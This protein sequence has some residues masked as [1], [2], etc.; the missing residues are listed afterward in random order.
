MK[1]GCYATNPEVFKGRSNQFALVPLK[2]S[3]YNVEIVNSIAS[4]TLTQTY[5]NPTET[6]LELE[7][8]FPINP[9][10]CL[11]K[12]TATFGKTKIEGIVKDSE[13]AKK[14]YEEAVSEGKKAAI[15]DLDSHSK[16]IFN[17]RVGNVPP[18]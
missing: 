14:E 12:F 15:G 9:K 5:F 16:D 1:C 7:Y 10:A 11:D 6:F 17:L 18:G 8:N 13:E 3:Q 4:I 2:S